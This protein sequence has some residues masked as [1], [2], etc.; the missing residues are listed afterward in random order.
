MKIRSGSC[1]IY[2]TVTNSILGRDVIVQHGAVVN[3]SIIMQSCV[4]EQ[5]ARVEHAIVDRN[6]T[7]PAST[8]LRGTPDAILIKEKGN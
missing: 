6:I 8:E 1:R 4:I 2:G 7:V 5:G 3:D